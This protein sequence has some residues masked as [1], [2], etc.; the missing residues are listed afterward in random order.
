MYF[1]TIT[2]QYFK[3]D[4]NVIENE[5]ITC[6]L[7]Y[8][9]FLSSCKLFLNVCI[10]EYTFI[11]WQVDGTTRVKNMVLFEQNFKLA[12]LK[13][14]KGQLHLNVKQAQILSYMYI[15]RS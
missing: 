10:V 4:K 14:R 7:P 6:Y 2:L 13:I 8:S 3:D 9:M 11:A 1:I 15:F 12:N 5:T